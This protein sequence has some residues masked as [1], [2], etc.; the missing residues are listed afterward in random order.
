MVACK[1]MLRSHMCK[2]VCLYTVGVLG[3]SIEEFQLKD[4]CTLLS[5]C[6]CH[7]RLQV[8]AL[9]PLRCPGDTQEDSLPDGEREMDNYCCK[10]RLLVAQSLASQLCATKAGCW[11]R[12]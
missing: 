8:F 3:L 10:P 6:F 2:C 11:E 4:M 5:V 1:S 9:F 7:V 12:G